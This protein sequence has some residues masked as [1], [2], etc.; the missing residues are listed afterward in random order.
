MN[1]DTKLLTFIIEGYNKDVEKSITYNFDIDNKYDIVYGGKEVMTKVNTKYVTYIKV[2]NKQNMYNTVFLD[3][4]IKFLEENSYDIIYLSSLLE[5]DD[6]EGNFERVNYEK[7]NNNE[8]A[9]YKTPYNPSSNQ[10]FHNV[11][12]PWFFLKRYYGDDVA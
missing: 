6:K 1:K 4:V 3:D 10:I 12:I 2:N 8:S 7:I 11:E 5:I 9:I